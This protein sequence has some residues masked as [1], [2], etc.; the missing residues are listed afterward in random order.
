VAETRF[1]AV[2][3]A[4]DRG[5][6]DPVAAAAGVA[7]KCLTP[8]AGTPMVMRVVR[9]LRQ[10]GRID[11]ILLCGP[12][13]RTVEGSPRIGQVTK[14]ESFAAV[15]TVPAHEGGEAVAAFEHLAQ[16]RLR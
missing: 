7:A 9:A 3:L 13:A 5:R 4:A 1:A 15:Q 12:D 16:D 8:I 11:D 2:V 10:S 14:D 6:N